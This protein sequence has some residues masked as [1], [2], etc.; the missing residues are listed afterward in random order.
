MIDDPVFSVTE[1]GISAPSYEEIYEYL[2]G[3]MRAIFGDDINLDADTQDGQMVGIVA[4]AISDVNAQAIAVYNAYNPTTAKG[5]AL[6][7]AVKVNGITRQAASHSQVDLRIVGQAG[8]HI[9]NGVALDEAENKWN[10][11][12]DVVVPPAGEITVTAIAAE[13]GDIRAPAGTVNRIGTPTLGWQ[14]VENILAAEPGAPV[15]TDLELRAQQSKSTALPSVSLW[16]GII[17]SLL[18]TA[19][20]RRVS[21]IKNDGDT[22]TTEGVPGHSIAMIVDGGEVADI[23]KTIFLKKGE[24]VGT[25]GSTSYNYLD[26]YGFPNTIRFSRPTVVPAYCKLTISPAADYLS[27]AED[28]IKARIVSYINSLDIGES[29]NITRVLASAV[30]TDAGIVD[31]RFGVEA[32]TLGR[33]TTAQAAASL[34]IAWNEA[35]SCAPENVTVEVQT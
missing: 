25:Y 34:A 12:A 23:A 33:S 27:S 21:G 17:G 5:V 13:E 31:E 14:T 6:D 9:V 3:R 26:T 15:Q 18:T 30:K 32:I 20:V 10:L 24:G 28:E 35:V 16:E 7:S 19:G 8:T 11:P 29:V 4:A 2:K 22:P 1:T